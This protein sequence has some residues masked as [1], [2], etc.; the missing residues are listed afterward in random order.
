MKEH[1]QVNM[2][3][4]ECELFL[5][6]HWQELSRKAIKFVFMKNEYQERYHRRLALAW[7]CMAGAAIMVFLQ[8]GLGYIALLQYQYTVLKAIEAITQTSL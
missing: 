7:Q 2:S 5:R 4:G 3:G 1:H 8:L 6:E